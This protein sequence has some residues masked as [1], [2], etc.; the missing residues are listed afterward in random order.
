MITTNAPN[1]ELLC[2]V[3]GT[4]PLVDIF[5]RGEHITKHELSKHNERHK[6]DF[7]ENNYLWH[8]PYTIKSKVNSTNLPLFL[9]NYH[10]TTTCRLTSLEIHLFRPYHGQ[11]AQQ[12][13]P[14]LCSWWLRFPGQ[15]DCQVRLEIQ[16]LTRNS[17]KSDKY[18]DQTISGLNYLA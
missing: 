17:I 14:D 3:T 5:T 9:S 11:R 4:Y 6:L 16:Y 8:S 15:Y 2:H 18:S 13:W 10:K 7:S 1:A 12:N